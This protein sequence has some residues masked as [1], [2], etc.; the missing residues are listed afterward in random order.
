MASDE[1]RIYV[2]PN[3][4]KEVFGN[5]LPY[6][7]HKDLKGVPQKQIKIFADTIAVC[8]RIDRYY[9][10][11]AFSKTRKCK[12]VKIEAVDEESQKGKRNGFRCYFLV[13]NI[14][15]RA[16]LLHAYPKSKQVDIPHGDYSVLAKFV[17]DYEDSL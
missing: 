5:N 11:I 15:K 9:A 2:D 13:D 12:C 1:Y 8:I 3:N 4:I 10:K 16:I 14:N 7:L 17:Q 6:N